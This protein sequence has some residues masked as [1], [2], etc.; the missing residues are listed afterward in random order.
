MVCKKCGIKIEGREKFCSNCGEPVALEAGESAA[1]V[2]EP[3]KDLVWNIEGYPTGQKEKKVEEVIFD[4]K[5]DNQGENFH[6]DNFYSDDKQ[7][8]TAQRLLDEELELINANSLAREEAISRARNQMQEPMEVVVIEPVEAVALDLDVREETIPEG[9]NEPIIS[10]PT[11][12]DEDI[13][14][15]NKTEL[16]YH[17]IFVEEEEPVEKPKSFLFR[18]LLLAIIIILLLAEASFLGLTYFLPENPMVKMMNERVGDSISTIASWFEPKEPVVEPVPEAEPVEGI[19]VEEPGTKE[20]VKQEPINPYP[21]NANIKAI[22]TNPDLLYVAGKDYSNLDINQSLPTTENTDAVVK[23]VVAYDSKWIDYVNNGDKSVVAL[24][25]PG[26]PAEKSTLSFT[27]IGKL[28]ETFNSLEIGEV[29]KGVKGY[30]VWVRE[31]IQIEEGGTNTTKVYNWI[32]QITP[33]QN[34]MK[35]V[36]YFSYN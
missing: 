1:I 21:E 25:A 17:D 20:P 5:T 33:I 13:N 24:T 28:K 15:A 18:K 27:K 34:E 6:V 30:Y 4:W 3:P 32:Y 7:N 8:I 22:T 9:E 2:L 35:I 23:T 19:T 29:R 16:K 10:I 14:I 11:N 31:G 12:E 36:N 26:S